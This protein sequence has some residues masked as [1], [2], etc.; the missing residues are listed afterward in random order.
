MG[1][2]PSDISGRNR[3]TLRHTA[4]R[5]D[6]ITVA[7]VD[8]FNDG[9]PLEPLG[10]SFGELLLSQSG[11]IVNALAI[12]AA[13]ALLVWLGLRPALK[14]VLEPVAAGASLPGKRLEA[15]GG[16]LMSDEP[17]LST[18][19]PS[20][21]ADLKSKLDKTPLKRLEQM[22]DFDEEQAAAILKQWMREAR[23]SQTADA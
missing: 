4:D 18:S 22:V 11:T 15:G 13:T 6:R 12:L 3:T 7:A 19:E 14:A 20:L 23:S 2:F 8:F 10:M 9:E 1:D 5:G 16:P 17:T 21:I